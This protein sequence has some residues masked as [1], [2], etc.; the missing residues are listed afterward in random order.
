MESMTSTMSVA[1]S[2][3]QA[4][5]GIG[6]SATTIAFATWY[7]RFES[8]INRLRSTVFGVSLAL[9]LFLRFGADLRGV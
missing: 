8:A 5:S 6:G 9:S 4:P 3:L 7:Q 2:L 1:M